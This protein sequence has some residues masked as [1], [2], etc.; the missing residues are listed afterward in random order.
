MVTGGDLR[1]VRVNV[2][3]FLLEYSQMMYD[4]PF[5]EMELIYPFPKVGWN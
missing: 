4:L 2:R 5:L 1:R 3:K